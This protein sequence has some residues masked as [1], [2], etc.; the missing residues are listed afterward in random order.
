MYQKKTIILYKYILTNLS[1]LY[2][3]GPIYTTLLLKIEIGG[4]E[5][6]ELL[7]IISQLIKLDPDH[8]N[9]YKSLETKI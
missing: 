7:D 5:K 1:F 8:K 2:P 4:F 3:T 6:Q 9:Y